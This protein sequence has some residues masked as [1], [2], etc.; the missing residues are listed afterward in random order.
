MIQKVRILE[1]S[2]PIKNDPVVFRKEMP[3]EMKAKIA[4]AFLAFAATPEG[5][6]AYTAIYGITDLKRATDKDYEP[7]IA[8][9]KATGQ[10]AEELLKQKK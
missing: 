8:M 1:L 5:K 9:L 3:E 4:D 10:S 2:E 6:A 7:A